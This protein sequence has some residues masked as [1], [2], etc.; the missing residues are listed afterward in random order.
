MMACSRRDWGQYYLLNCFQTSLSHLPLFEFLQ[1]FIHREFP[2]LDFLLQEDEFLLSSSKAVSY[3]GKGLTLHP[4]SVYIM[5][6]GF[7]TSQYMTAGKKSTLR[8]KEFEYLV[9][10]NL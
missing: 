4:G 8:N 9:L 10:A 2:I 5:R 7:L 3:G 6:E 1:G